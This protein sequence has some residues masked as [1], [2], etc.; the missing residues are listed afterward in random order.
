MPGVRAQGWT[1][2]KPHSLIS[3]NLKICG[4][5]ALAIRHLPLFFFGNNFRFNIYTANF[6]QDA[7]RI[8]SRYSRDASVITV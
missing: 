8:A 5:S 3:K 1:G 4:H 6:A 2:L 7:C